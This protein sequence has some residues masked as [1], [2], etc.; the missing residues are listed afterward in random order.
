[1]KETRS[2]KETAEKEEGG[3]EVNGPVSAGMTCTETAGDFCLGPKL[4]LREPKVAISQMREAIA[5]II[6]ERTPT[7]SVS[8]GGVAGSPRLRFGLV[9]GALSKYVFGA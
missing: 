6:H 2:G 3:R 9:S 7:R 5:R 1:M 4:S 8:E